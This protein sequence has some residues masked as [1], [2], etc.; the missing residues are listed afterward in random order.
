MAEVIRVLDGT[1][2]VDLP[3]PPFASQSPL[4]KVVRE[5]LWNCEGSPPNI[6]VWV[7][8]RVSEGYAGALFKATR[9]LTEKNRGR[10]QPQYQPHFN[11]GLNLNIE[12]TLLFII[13]FGVTV[14]ILHSGTCDRNH[15]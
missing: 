10:V 5:H 2:S 11:R 13:G 12:M 7:C 4:Q 3:L 14:V 9:A 6:I 1:L 8:R 15:Q